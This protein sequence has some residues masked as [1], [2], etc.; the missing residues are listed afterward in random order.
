MGMCVTWDALDVANG[1][2]SWDL[3]VTRIS[4]IRRIGPI[5]SRCP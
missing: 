3:W 2:D 5:G 4:L 1:W